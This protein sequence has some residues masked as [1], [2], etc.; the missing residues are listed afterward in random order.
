MQSISLNRPASLA[1]VSLVT[2]CQLFELRVRYVGRIASMNGRR[3]SRVVDAMAH[4]DR[5]DQKLIDNARGW[6]IWAEIEY[7]DSPTDYREYLV[8]NADPT[9]PGHFVTLDS[10]RGGEAQALF[11]IVG[12][13]LIIAAAYL[14]YSILSVLE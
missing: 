11:L 5:A 1:S 8:T 9:K 3:H 12:P 4:A 13:M 6:E 14:L 2:C 10:E 7:L